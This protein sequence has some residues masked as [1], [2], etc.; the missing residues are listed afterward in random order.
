MECCRSATVGGLWPV[1]LPTDPIMP[2]LPGVPSFDELVRRWLNLAERRLSHFSELYS[3]GR[4]RRYYT[5]EQFAD[6]VTDV[7]KAV[8]A[9]SKLAGKPP[10]EP[11][12]GSAGPAA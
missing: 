8:T 5:P 12:S 3:G 2:G 6:R 7:K 4:W 1:G 10:K 11:P 9:W